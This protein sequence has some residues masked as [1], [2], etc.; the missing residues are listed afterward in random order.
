MDSHT[1][2]KCLLSWKIKPYNINKSVLYIS[3]YIFVSDFNHLNYT[4]DIKY[5]DFLILCLK[6]N[7]ASDKSVNNYFL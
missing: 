1:S 2:F 3:A 6:D 5:F 7:A 4:G